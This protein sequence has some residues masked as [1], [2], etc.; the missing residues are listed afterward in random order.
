MSGQRPDGRLWLGTYT[1]DQGDGRGVYRTRG[2]PGGTIEPPALAAEA[3]KPSYLA[4]H[5]GGRVL[6]T[7]E[8]LA[9]G[10]ITAYRVEDGGGLTGLG[11]R[12]V[13]AE[14]CHLSVSPDGAHLLV[15]CYGPGVLGL[16]RLDADGGFDGEPALWQGAGTGPV[17]GRQE[18]PHAHQTLWTPG[19]IVLSTDLGADR[20]HAFRVRGGAL[21]PVG[22]NPLP[23]GYGPR[24]LALH[25]SGHVFAMMELAPRLLVLRP[26]D[27]HAELDIVGEYVR[28]EGSGA[29]VALGAGGAHLYASTRGADVVGTYRVTSGGAALEHLGDVPSGGAGPRDLEVDGDRLYVANEQG[30]TVA[31]FDLDPL[32]VPAGPPAP[33]PTPVCVLAG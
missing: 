6:Y 31:A 33:A 1:G 13:P 4:L 18:G 5:P 8:E 26:R 20:I 30:G 12:A 2:V 23:A 21:V 25:P 24:H 28:A 10:R 15:A 7:V 9:D 3:P 14:P 19:G 11:T 22:E 27:S 16:Q 32:P 29:A 17:A